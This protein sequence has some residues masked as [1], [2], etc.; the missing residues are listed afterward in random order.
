MNCKHLL[1]FRTVVRCGGVSRAAAELHLTAQ[2]LSGQIKL[3]EDRLGHRLLRKSGRGVEA[4]EAGRDAVRPVARSG[5]LPANR[6]QHV[7]HVV[8][9]ETERPVAVRPRG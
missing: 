8:V 6:Q 1:Y 5:A 9:R 2:T 7:G 3:L 4:T